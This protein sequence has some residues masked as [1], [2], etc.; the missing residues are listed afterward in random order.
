MKILIATY[1]WSGTTQRLADNIAKLLPEADQYK[2][3]VPE[4][5]FSNDM[6][7]TNDIATEQIKQN[8]YP[9][10]A[11]KLP[12]TDKYDLILV[13]SPVW[14]GQPATPIHSFLNLIK[15]Y[16][17]KIAPFYTDVGNPGHF[18]TTFNQWAGNL[19]VLPGHDG[20]NDLSNWI[21]KLMN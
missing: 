2:I 12:N 14:S 16:Q 9:A 18:E 3:K 6:Y 4:H 10:L 1:S 11:N 15:N 5:T 21:A 17:G 19:N 7:K 13:G 8:N 20:F